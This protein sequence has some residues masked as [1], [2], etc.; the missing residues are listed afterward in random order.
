MTAVQQYWIVE[1]DAVLV[2][3]ITPVPVADEDALKGVASLAGYQTDDTPLDGMVGYT[4]LDSVVLVTVSLPEYDNPFDASDKLKGAP[5]LTAVTIA[6]AQVSY[7][8]PH[9]SADKWK[10]A[11]SLS[12]VTVLTV[13]VTYANLYDST[14]KMKGAPALSSVVIT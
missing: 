11:P 1:N 3:N 5:G 9:D 10:G 14:D 12:G 13:V 6:A 7:S 4:S 2:S 8:N